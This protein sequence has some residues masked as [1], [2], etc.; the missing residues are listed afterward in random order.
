KL[1][2]SKP[3]GGDLRRRERDVTHLL[4]RLDLDEGRKW[5]AGCNCERVELAPAHLR[6]QLRPFAE[7]EMHGNF[8]RI[9]QLWEI[10][11]PRP[12]ARTRA[13]TLDAHIGYGADRGFLQ[14]EQLKG[15]VVHG[16]N[17]AHGARRLLSGP[18][19][20]AVPGLQRNSRR[21][22]AESRLALFQELDVL[23]RPFG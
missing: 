18:A 8:E 20:G 21:D 14:N 6:R 2:H 4:L 17:R 13:D 23:R 15:R 7:S 12:A 11:G 3:Q 10:G 5:N 1:R 16:E 19:A 22:E 9:E